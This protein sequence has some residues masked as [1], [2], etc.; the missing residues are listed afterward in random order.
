MPDTSS[1]PPLSCPAVLR[2]NILRSQFMH[3][4]AAEYLR[5]DP[6]KIQTILER[7]EFIRQ[8]TPRSGPYF[9]KWEQLL[10]GPLPELIAKMTEM[11]EEASDLRKASPCLI[12]LTHE[13]RNEAFQRFGPRLD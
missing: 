3:Q 10:N 5:E 2:R 6:S 1:F 12:I 11:S 9:D 8:V 7:L 4:R 13:D